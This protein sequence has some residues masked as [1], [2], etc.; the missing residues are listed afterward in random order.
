[1]K[2]VIKIGLLEKEKV[3][4]N[5][6]IAHFKS[7]GGHAEKYEMKTGMPDLIC[8]YLGQQIYIEVKRE[9]RYKVSVIQKAQ[10]RKLRR[11]GYIAIATN[12]FQDVLELI[13]VIDNVLGHQEK[14]IV[15]MV[16]SANKIGME[17][18]H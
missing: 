11:K 4:E 5:R 2:E 18:E 7:L 15:R 6:I 3:L 8:S 9:K 14:K 10:I 16:Q 13:N 1:M 17:V 12:D